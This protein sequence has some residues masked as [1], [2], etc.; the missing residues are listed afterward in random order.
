TRQREVV[1]AGREH[2]GLAVEVGP[3]LPDA[4]QDAIVFVKRIEETGGPKA[5][6]RADGGGVKADDD[7]RFRNAGLR[8]VI[9]NGVENGLA[10]QVQEHLV[11]L[12][13]QVLEAR[14][15]PCR[16]NESLHSSSSPEAFLGPCRRFRVVSGTD[17][18][19][20]PRKRKRAN[21]SVCDRHRVA[22]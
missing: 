22:W 11:A 14:A 15:Q 7:V 16:C 21:L 8:G 20:A 1:V 17:L 10:A 9:Q 6:Q 13:A 4:A 5:G 18:N 3:R 2:E 19:R 12:L